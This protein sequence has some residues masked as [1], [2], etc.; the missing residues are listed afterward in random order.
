MST[1]PTSS[2][3]GAISF[4]FAG[5]RSL[6]ASQ[7]ALSQAQLRLHAGDDPQ[8][9]RAELGWFQGVDEKWRYEVSDKAAVLNKDLLRNLERGGLPA[10]D[11]AKVTYRHEDDGTWSL[12]LV[13]ENPQTLADMVSLHKLP[14]SFARGLLPEDLWERMQ[15][16]EGVESIIGAD[17]DEALEFDH[18]FRFGGFNALPLAD[19]LHHPALYEAYPALRQIYLQVNPKLANGAAYMKAIDTDGAPI[20]IIAIGHPRIKG[21]LGRVMHEVQHAI[22]EL[23]HFAPGGMVPPTE[24]AELQSI[25]AR[26]QD[27]LQTNTAFAALHAEHQEDWHRIQD[28]HAVVDAAGGKT[29]MWDQVPVEDREAYFSRENQLHG[30]GEH[31]EYTAL[32]SQA[33]AIKPHAARNF[34]GY[35]RLAGE[36]EARNVEARLDMSDSERAI[37]PPQAT[38]D[39]PQVEQIVR[40]RF[41]DP[42][43]EIPA[44][45]RL[46]D[47]SKH[48]DAITQFLRGYP[49]RPPAG[50]AQAQY[51]DF[52]RGRREGL[53]ALVRRITPDAEGLLL[54]VRSGGFWGVSREPRPDGESWRVTRFDANMEPLGHE[55]HRDAEGA[56][57]DVL[58]WT[59]LSR[60]QPQPV[61]QPAPTPDAQAQTLLNAAA[62]A[63]AALDREDAEFYEAAAA[64]IIEHGRSF[65]AQNAVV[66]EATP[67]TSLGGP[68]AGLEIT[69]LFADVPGRGDGTRILDFM[70]ALAD[71]A[72]MGI[73]L[74]P[75]SPRNR[76][77]YARMGYS[78]DSGYYT[79]MVRRPKVNHDED[80]LLSPEPPSLALQARGRAFDAWFGRSQA[81]DHR[82]KPLELFHGTGADITTFD[83][84]QTDSMQANGNR[85]GAWGSYFTQSPTEASIYAEMAGTAGG[86]PNVIPVHLSIQNPYLMTRGEW[87]GHSMASA[88]M[89]SN[90][91]GRAYAL[92]VREKLES[93]GHDGIV[94]RGRGFNDEWVAFRPEQI[95]SAIGN[96]GGYRRDHPDI[97][98]SMPSAQATPAKTDSELAQ[99]FGDSVLVDAKGQPQLHYHGTDKD[100]TEFD[101]MASARWRT[102]S[103][104]TIGLWFSD[105]PSNEGGAGMYGSKVIPVYLKASRPKHY[106]RHQDL[107]RDMV[108]ANGETYVQGESS[109]RGSPEALRA[110]LI[111]QGYDAITIDRSANGELIGDIQAHISAVHDARTEE[112][113]VAR[114]QRGPF[115]MKRER[116]EATL[117]DL[118]AQAQAIGADSTEF[119]RQTAV[120]VFHPDQIR[121]A[122]SSPADSHGPDTTQ[123]EDGAS[124][125]AAAP[126][127]LDEHGAPLIAFHGTPN[128]VF[129]AFDTTPTFFTT[130][131][132]AAQGYATDRYARDDGDGNVPVVVHAHLSMKNPKV[133][134]EQELAALL[135]GDAGPDGPTIEWSDFDNLAFELEDQGFDGVIIRNAYDFL[136]RTGQDVQRGRYDQYVVFDAG[137]IKVVAHTDAVRHHTQAQAPGTE[138][139]SPSAAAPGDRMA[140]FAKWFGDS[141]I[142]TADGAPRVMFH[143]TTADISAFDAERAVS[144]DAGWY[145]RGIYFT[146]DPGTASA[147]T[148]Y[149]QLQAGTKEPAEGANVMP[150]HLSIVNPYHWPASRLPAKNPEEAAQIRAELE[151]A[152]FDG[153]VFAQNQADPQYASHYEVVAFRAEQI[154]SASGNNGQ[155]RL[156]SPDIR[157]SSVVQLAPAGTCTTPERLRLAMLELLGDDS[158]LGERLGK[159]IATTSHDFASRWAHVIGT[160]AAQSLAATRSQGLFDA[161]S[162]TVFLLSDNIETGDE[163]AVLTHELMHKHGQAVLGQQGWSQLTRSLEAWRYAPDGSVEQEIFR[164]A[165]ARVINSKPPGTSFEAHTTNEL[166]PYAVEIA[167]AKGVRPSHSA[168]AGTASAWLAQVRDA[169]VSTW[170]KII[171]KPRSVDAQDLVDLAWGIAQRERPATTTKFDAATASLRAP[172]PMADTTTPNF[173]AWF[174]SSMVVDAHGQPKV[175]YHGTRRDFDVFRFDKIGQQGRAEGAGFYFSDTERI[176]DAYGI[177]MEVYLSIQKPMAYDKKAFPRATM[178]AILLAAA[179]HEAS[180]GE[181]DIQDG[182]L[183][184]YGDVAC[185]GLER[186]ARSAATGLAREELAIDQLGDMVAA[187]LQVEHLNAAVHEVTGYDGIVSNGYSNEGAGEHQIYVAFF[188]EQVKS[189]RS[190]SGQFSTTDPNI[191]HSMPAHPRDLQ[192][193][194]LVRAQTA[195]WQRYRAAAEAEGLADLKAGRSLHSA[196]ILA[197]RDSGQLHPGH[198]QFLPPADCGSQARARERMAT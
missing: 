48:T 181:R 183:S 32:A 107:V 62:A 95:K 145:G 155:Y 99:W 96:N 46:P 104:D 157:H 118:R 161:A 116:L 156:D 194:R 65:A 18:G 98:F 114:A 82:G 198:P 179:R 1:I 153:V 45:A 4:S 164:E 131:F 68:T 132:Q 38:A 56:I 92:A 174:K 172:R 113:S 185:D 34:D 43:G 76:A 5:E 129:H 141:K 151:A 13:K 154:K 178:Q 30:F 27:L 140:A 77:Y 74:R 11:V 176:A 121:R 165:C 42:Q 175:V 78:D 171:G 122:D 162:Q 195:A 173:K 24:P 177:P 75:S 166:F 47:A 117:K 71:Y 197:L 80:E 8:T 186:V 180:A 14:T 37:T 192:E 66:L 61:P 84:G 191:H 187:G 115:T 189:A 87:Q 148:R 70:G 83:T 138:A 19:A 97:R 60:L 119:D 20:Q 29:V 147:Y 101:R 125:P 40:K 26:M 73:Y 69:D 127:L 67:F 31:F 59:D 23:E 63:I 144:K 133:Y 168:A 134:T 52:M 123:P 149:L 12:L 135:P 108:E 39:V 120:V 3:P 196:S 90:T 128:G 167:V 2:A 100:F 17:L 112:F 86:A 79:L 184:A 137:Q 36:V 159:V 55:S 91:D 150:V 35:W 54:P 58:L 143:G 21:A 139:E 81:V 130:S 28:R 160:N 85:T 136:G 94:I 22:Q 6:S 170:A 102:T 110:A 105:N 64:L 126:F 193:L 169:L 72:G 182:Y 163:M 16:R 51:R 10:I 106:S 142:I 93:E 25:Q 158:A 57:E 146:S 50:M 190:N 152:G 109:G 15:A 111:A 188:R 44:A 41:Q 89:D 33:L 7:V 124:A 49:T 53:Q 103:L 9:V 88:K